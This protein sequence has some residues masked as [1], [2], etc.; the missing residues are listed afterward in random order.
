MLNEL[1]ITEGLLM[2]S[3]RNFCKTMMSLKK[4]A[5][6]ILVKGMRVRKRIN[7]L[8][9]RVLEM[10]LEKSFSSLPKEWNIYNQDKVIIVFAILKRLI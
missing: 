7:N 3:S 8:L 5:V 6:D 1:L 10:R 4:I 9:Q 2:L